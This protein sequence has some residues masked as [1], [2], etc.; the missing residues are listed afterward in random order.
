MSVKPDP[1]RGTPKKIKLKIMLR[2]CLLCLLYI[3][4][5]CSFN[6][7]TQDKGAAYLQGEWKETNVP[8]AAD[9]VEFKQ[10]DFKFTCD[11]FYVVLNNFSKA[12]FAQDTC[13]KTGKWKEYAKGTYILNGDTLHLKGAYASKSFKLKTSPCYTTG[14][15]DETLLLQSQRDSQ[16]VFKSFTSGQIVL[17]L[18]KLLVCNSQSL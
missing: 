13:Y 7:N 3:F 16:L 17:K 11:S 4:S 8:F 6:R 14:V 2:N 5:A 15:F 9:L 12:N 1:F 10:R 18:Q